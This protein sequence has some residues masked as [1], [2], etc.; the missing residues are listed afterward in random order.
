MGNEQ[1]KQALRNAGLEVDDLAVRAEVDVKTARR[2]LSGRT[3]RAR[4]RRRVAD[5][6][7]VP[8][9][10]LWPGE[11]PDQEPADDTEGEGEGVELLTAADAPDWREL[12]AD[13]RERVLL[14][15][16]TLGDM[17]GNGDGELLADAGARGC[18][19]RVLVSD[20]DSVHLAIAEQDAGRHVDLTSRPRS[21][22]ELLHERCSHT[23]APRA[24]KASSV[25]A[26]SNRP[27]M[28][29]RLPRPTTVIR[30]RSATE[31]PT[32]GQSP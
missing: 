18:R 23:L 27:V 5:T 30:R 12:L 24:A 32:R 20:P 8:E 31:E 17:I 25:N 2:W 21:A 14:L 28:S 15:D 22:A 9:Q 3:P 29:N 7:G 19:V 13:A 10:V 4:Y 11:V 16:L 6:L 1:L 26:S